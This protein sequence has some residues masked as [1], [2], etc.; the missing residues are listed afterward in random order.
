[1]Q[2]LDSR[3]TGEWDIHKHTFRSTQ[4]RPFLRASYFGLYKIFVKN[5]FLLQKSLEYDSGPKNFE[6]VDE[7]DNFN[8]FYACTVK[9]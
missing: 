3:E 1:M 8:G 7:I 2:I 5:K 6:E 9:R 4:N